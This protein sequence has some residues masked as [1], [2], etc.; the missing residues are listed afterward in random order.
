MVHDA[1][2]PLLG[3]DICGLPRQQ[4]QKLFLHTCTY[5]QHVVR[6]SMLPFVPTIHSMLHPG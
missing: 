3:A 6:P 4:Y 5:E 1:A 2:T